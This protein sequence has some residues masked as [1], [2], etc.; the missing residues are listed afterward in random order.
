VHL[1][2]DDFGTGYSSFSYLK[3]LPLDALKIDR[4]FVREV[5][6]S[7]DDAAITTAIIAMGHALGLHVV[8]EGIETEA[9]RQVLL[10]QGCDEMQGYLFSRPVP[11]E[12]LAQ[13]LAASA[14]LPRRT[15]RLRT[16]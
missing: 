7:L 2:V 10:E 3:H 15:R 14:S 6:M 5:T 4:S 12:Q 9:Q 1:A 11:P 16:A 8:G 13:V